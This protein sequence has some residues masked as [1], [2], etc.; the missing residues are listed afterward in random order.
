MRTWRWLE[1]ASSRV[2]QGTP[3][4]CCSTPPQTGHRCWRWGQRRHIKY[5][6]K[7]KTKIDG[8]KR[9]RD[10]TCFPGRSP[11]ATPCWMADGAFQCHQTQTCSRTSWCRTTSVT[12]QQDWPQGTEDL[13][14]LDT[15]INIRV[16]SR[17]WSAAS[18]LLLST[19]KEEKLEE[20][21]QSSDVNNG[22]IRMNPWKTETTR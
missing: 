14:S 22:R 11:A 12:R 6:S 9:E 10:H 18:H 1:V 7:P 8:Q 2:H 4:R 15:K 20:T 17:R 13:R 16:Q 3:V 19:N 21:F 5:F